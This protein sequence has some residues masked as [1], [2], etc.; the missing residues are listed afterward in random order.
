M[1]HLSLSLLL[2]GAPLNSPI[3]ARADELSK[4]ALA[5]ADEPRGAAPLI[6]L[7]ALLDDV[8]DLNI[9]AE[10]YS[11][12][13]FRRNT[14]ANV[15]ILAKRF[16]AEV[17]RARGRTVKA[18]ELMDSL[19]YVQKWNVIGGFENEG[20]SGCDKDFGP[21]SAL[22]LQGSYASATRAVSWHETTQKSFDGYVDLSFALKPSDEAVGYA[23]TFIQATENTAVEMSVGSSGGF[24]LFV[25]QTKVAQDNREHWP[26]PDQNRVVVNVR[27]GINRVLLKVCQNKGPFGFYFRAERAAGA[28]GTFEIISLPTV[29]PLEKGTPA[30]GYPLVTLSEALE[31]QLKA[32]PQD[33]LLRLDAATVL[34]FTKNYDEKEQDSARESARAALA[35]ETDP[36]AQLTAATL[37][38]DA[39]E[40]RNFIQR[41]L[42]ISAEH[43]FA[44]AMWAQDRLS[45]ERP[46]EALFAAE[47]LL[48][49]N[50]L[51]STA[52]LIKVNALNDLGRKAE[53]ALAI[54]SAFE[55]L[56]QIPP[57]VREAAASSRR[58][59]RYTETL[60]R[61]RVALALRFDDVNTR[62][63]LASQ[64]IDLGQFDEAV[65]Q[66]NK[67]L[68]LD[69]YD[70]S[71]RLRLGEWL[72]ANGKPTEA[73]ALFD[74]ALALAPDDAD[75]FERVG[76]ANLRAGQTELGIEQ[77]AKALR[78]RPQNPALRDMLKTLRHEDEAAA[79]AQAFDLALLAKEAPNASESDAVTLADV[80]AV[81]VQQS[82][83]S[84][85][86]SQSVVKVFSQRGV[87]AFRQIPLTWS[88]DRQ[89]LTVMKARIL[90]P[91]GSLLESFSAAES[92]LN[93]PWTG[94]YYD[95]RAKVLSFPQLAPG[96]I[97]E[98]QYR[99]ED[100]AIDNLLSDYWG[101]VD[102]VQGTY[103]KQHYR[104]RIEM[105]Q[106]RPLYWNKSQLPAWVS[107]K[108]DTSG[109][110]SAYQFEAQHVARIVPEPNMPGWAEM[111][112]VL[113]VSTYENWEKVGRY[114]WGL[115][116]EQLVPNDEIKRAVDDILKGVDRK[117]KEKVVAA[118]YGFVVTNT[119]YVALEFGIHGYK[120]Y[121]VDTILSR[122]FGDCKDKASLI[123]SMLQVA[124]VEA[125]LVLLR[126]RH[127]G[128]LS[129]E[130]ASLSAFNH[131]I[132]YVPE[133]N[134]FLDGTAEFH[135]TKELPS[136]DRLANV[137]VVEPDGVSTFR[138]IE[139]ATPNDNL[140][141]QRLTLTLALDGSVKA[142]GMLTTKGQAA[143]EV[144]RKYETLATRST[145]F[146]NEW[147]Q[148]FPGAKASKVVAENLSLEAPTQISFEA[149]FPRF[150][151]ASDVELRFFP[152]GAPRIFTQNMA[153]LAQRKTDALFSG[154]FEYSHEF[155]YELPKGFFVKSLP[156]VQLKSNFGE[157]K[158]EAAFVGLKLVVK[159]DMTLSATRIKASE[160]GEFRTWLMAVDQAFNTKISA[161]KL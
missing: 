145:V 125:R 52:H 67:V 1:L 76:K 19:G 58:Y 141:T 72:L 79:T 62:R 107:V 81:K 89:E 64:L 93:E 14:D 146:E 6:R 117:D 111:A 94:M 102:F 119:R 99:L 157:L 10:V 18:Q 39:N 24:R 88:P 142:K 49:M 21:E 4:L 96:D 59:E 87:E 16:M 122:K 38:I 22:D 17:E 100:T 12:L 50:P 152:L 118:I 48:K 23:L 66:A 25:N 33:A 69:A 129:S 110:N 43:P 148:L 36:D 115:V 40:R 8:D 144:R 5:Q 131:A 20:K 73:K 9:F 98:I 126:M 150:A 92:N 114:Y 136:A 103:E 135:G 161:T 156:S 124:G 104:Y 3:N 134:L 95:S 160:T 137:L 123:V 158:I 28:R 60:E 113:H 51:F 151:E 11:A 109:T 75:T 112:T 61:Q 13:I 86:F 57:I 46:N 44:K 82:G 53:S 65:V 31:K 85:R 70:S 159:A 106:L 45:N 77:L 147:G 27:K 154:V 116:R 2:L 91:D 121:R 78:L 105:P 29:P 101:D 71:L 55:V 30:V 133:F 127:L 35:L 90:K 149:Q 153:A 37:A 34:H 56:H 15:R 120:P 139:E 83:L 155:T 32:R 74:A 54:E 42:K 108:T 140:S 7:H 47:A 63:A 41:A 26:K 143:P 138:T 68:A 80:T 97:L 132:A 128:Q 84:S 130:V